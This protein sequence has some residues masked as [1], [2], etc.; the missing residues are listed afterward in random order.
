MNWVRNSLLLTLALGVAW[1]V[2][3]GM[4]GYALGNPSSA[5]Q[6]TGCVH[7]LRVDFILPMWKSC[8]T[9]QAVTSPPVQVAPSTDLSP[10]TTTTAPPPTTTTTPPPPPPCP[11]GFQRSSW[12]NCVDQRHLPCPPGYSGWQNS[13]IDNC[14]E[15]PTP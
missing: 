14:L 6:L 11:S 8:D 9:Q 12:G 4:N 13:Q 1:A 10:D 3:A 7:T 2:I 5:D 15:K